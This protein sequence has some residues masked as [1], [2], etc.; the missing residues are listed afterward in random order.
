MWPSTSSGVMPTLPIS[1]N[2]KVHLPLIRDSR[3]TA[4]GL[5][6]PTYWKTVEVRSLLH[7]KFG[8]DYCVSCTEK[9]RW[10]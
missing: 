2:G 1:D 5:Q 3:S 9:G 10:Q 8:F 4:C 6:I 7:M